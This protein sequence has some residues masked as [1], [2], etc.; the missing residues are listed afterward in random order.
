[1]RRFVLHPTKPSFSYIQPQQHSS[2]FRALT[3]LFD[4]IQVNVYRQTNGISCYRKRGQLSRDGF[5]EES[6]A[7]AR[8]AKDQTRTRS[9]PR[10]T[11]R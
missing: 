4:T 8:H 3:V 9:R 11:M 5:P 1:M 7:L 10:A 2:H 6:I